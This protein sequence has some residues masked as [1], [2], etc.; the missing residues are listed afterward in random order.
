MEPH[1]PLQGRINW[2]YT[3]NAWSLC[4]ECLSLQ[5]LTRLPA[6]PFQPTGQDH[7][8]DIVKHACCLYT[9]QEKLRR[10][11]IWMDNVWELTVD[12]TLEWVDSWFHAPFWC[13][14]TAHQKLLNPSE[15]KSEKYDKGNENVQFFVQHVQ[16]ITGSM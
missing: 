3:D 15:K 11:D 9:I 8:E 2:D 16:N 1:H 13:T 7:L 5:I 12:P 6:T 10:V 14:E 4:Q